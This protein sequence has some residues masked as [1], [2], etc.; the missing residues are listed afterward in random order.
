MKK[1][2]TSSSFKQT[3]KSGS[4]TF[5]GTLNNNLIVDTGTITIT[6]KVNHIVAAKDFSIFN[7]PVEI[8]SVTFADSIKAYSLDNTVIATITIDP[9]FEMPSANKNIKIKFNGDAKLFESKILDTVLT[10]ESNKTVND[11]G[12]IYATTIITPETDVTIVEYD[13]SIGVSPVPSIPKI[14][15]TIST[16]V[17]SMQPTTLATVRVQADDGY[18]FAKKP[19]LKSTF[20]DNIKLELNSITKN[21]KNLITDYYFKL[22]YKNTINTSALNNINAKLIC[23]AKAIKVKPLEIYKVLIGNPLISIVGD[24]RFV[25]VFGTPGSEFELSFTRKSTG[26]SILSNYDA[27]SSMLDPILGSINSIKKKIGKKGFYQFYQRFPAGYILSTKQAGSITNGTDHVYDSIENV[28]VGDQVLVKTRSVPTATK[29]LV[30]ELEPGGIANKLKFDT[31]VSITDNA[32]VIFVR[33]DEYYINI[34]AGENTTLG[35]SIP[36][37]TTHLPATSDGSIERRSYNYTFNQHKNPMLKLTVSSADTTHLELNG[38]AD[39][40]KIGKP[41][42]ESYKLK[43]LNNTKNYFSISYSLTPKGGHSTINEGAS[44]TLKFSNKELTTTDASGASVITSHWTNSVADDNGGTKISIFNIKQAGTGTGT[45]TITADV[46][47]Y[48]WGTESVTM[49]LDL[50]Q[51]ID[52]AA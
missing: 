46:I 44:P 37:K 48:K 17:K 30:T 20:K 42:T 28:L 41:N 33:S 49:N 5:L 19:Y 39:I 10:I 9:S 22:V 8:K 24:T 4:R 15:Y 47:V 38:A 40:V 26:E 14:K 11:Y 50:D 13:N 43:H 1:N 25:R 31:A 12:N 51:I 52:T 45:Y 36:E 27:N 2:Y 23:N 29:V 18:Y 7:L 32:D 16:T 35:S 3:V 6:P 21:S 34:E